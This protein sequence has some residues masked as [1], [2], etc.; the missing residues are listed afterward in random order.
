MHFNP[1]VFAKFNEGL[2]S[3]LPV[4]FSDMHLDVVRLGKSTGLGRLL[5]YVS[6]RWVKPHSSYTLRGGT[7]HRGKQKHSAKE[8][9]Q[10]ELGM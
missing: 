7:N 1:D 4:I 6:P 2:R 10:P 5:K 3:C 9:L 8:R